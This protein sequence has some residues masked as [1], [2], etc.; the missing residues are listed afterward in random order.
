VSCHNEN[1]QDLNDLLKRADEGLCKVK[2]AG[3]D[4]VSWVYH[5]FDSEIHS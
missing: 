2:A 4:R 3:R 5:P 1:D